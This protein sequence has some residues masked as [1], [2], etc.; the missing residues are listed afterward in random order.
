MSLNALFTGTLYL[1]DK[2]LASGTSPVMLSDGRTIAQVQ[3]HFWTARSKFEV[4][5]VPGRVIAEGGSRG[6]TARRYVVTTPD[7]RTLVEVK[8]GLWR[9]INSATITLSTG[10]ALSVKQTTI[11]SDRN[12]EF[13]SNGRPVG[14]ITPT[15][16]VFTFHPDSYAFE[17]TVPVMSTVEAISLAQTLRAVVRAARAARSG[18]T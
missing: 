6:L 1:P 18:S 5:D 4:L 12:F 8:L 3:W 11:W 2:A 7:G 15:T 17:L 9:P 13:F 14:R 10:S 16:G